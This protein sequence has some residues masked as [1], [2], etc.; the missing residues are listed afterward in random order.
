MVEPL[1]PAEAPGPAH[2]CRNWFRTV[3][4]LFSN[5]SRTVFGLFLN[6][7]YNCHYNSSPDGCSLTV[8][9]LFL[10]CYR[11]V[12]ELFSK[13]SCAPLG[14]FPDCYRAVP[15]LLSSTSCFPHN[16]GAPLQQR[17]RGQGPAFLGYTSIENSG[18][19]RS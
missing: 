15:G 12:L 1:A 18:W 8:L 14:L 13:C 3:L 2:L 7:H 9:K 10:D 11:T 5:C 19:A 6:C 4:K 17:Y 16:T